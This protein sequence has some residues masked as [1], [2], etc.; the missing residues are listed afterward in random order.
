MKAGVR[1]VIGLHI[2]LGVVYRQRW[3][4]E[5]RHSPVAILFEAFVRCLGSA[6]LTTCLTEACLAHGALSEL[7]ATLF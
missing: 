3:L 1:R 2:V 5:I 4:R 6:C 7:A